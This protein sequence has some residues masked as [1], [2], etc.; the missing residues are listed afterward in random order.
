MKKLLTIISVLTLGIAFVFAEGNNEDI[1]AGMSSNQR[2]EYL[3]KALSVERKS[4]TKTSTYGNTYNSKPGKY[5]T[6]GTFSSDT[7]T[8][9]TTDWIPYLGPSQIS[10]TEFFRLAKNDELYRKAME[11]DSRVKA[12]KQ[13][14]T[15]YTVVGTVAVLGGAAL[16]AIG[17]NEKNPN[18][19]YQVLGGVVMGV[20]CIPL[21]FGIYN[22]CYKEEMDVSVDFAIGVA[23]SYNK[24]L[25]TQIKLKFN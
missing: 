18:E 10:K 11:I 1:T 15:I 4:V 7:E 21:G 20:G 25:A 2:Q 3:N 22:L 13:S 8:S 12:K 24:D 17:E 9:T 5:G 16:L 6:S 14:G 23:N 19:L